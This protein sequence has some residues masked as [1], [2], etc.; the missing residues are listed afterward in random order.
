MEHDFRRR[1]RILLVM[2][3][4]IVFRYEPGPVPEAARLLRR[5]LDGWRGVGR[6]WSA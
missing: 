2:L 6:M 3:T 1:R 4:A 5:W